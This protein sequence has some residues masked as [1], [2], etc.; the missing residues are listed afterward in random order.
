M[1]R[2]ILYLVLPVLCSG[3]VNDLKKVEALNQRDIGVEVA[4]NITTYYYG[5]NGHLKGLLTAPILY[6]YLRDTPY[7]ELNNGL[8]V[9][10]YNDSMKVQSV[11]TARKGEYFENSNNIVV[12]DSV[13]VTTQDGKRLETE[14]LHW[15]PRK[16]QFYTDKPATLTTPTQVIY[17]QN[18]LT[19]PPDISWYRFRKAS[20]ELKVDTGY[21][22]TPP[23]PDTGAASRSL[24]PVSGTDSTTIKH[25]NK[26]SITQRPGT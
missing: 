24:S 2:F 15:D 5:I 18:G 23:P 22:S 4:K 6:R 25:R 10:F 14:E 19:A 1:K 20:G 17:A 21:F 9:D 12:S 13:V 8:R 7:M 11:L 26:D 16:Q 3:C